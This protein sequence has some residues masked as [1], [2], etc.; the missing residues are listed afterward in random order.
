MVHG[1]FNQGNA[2]FGETA[3]IQCNCMALFAISYSAIKEINRWSQPDLDIV[4]VNGMLCTK[5]L[6]DKHY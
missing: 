3:R 6:E 2:L 5:P 1:S 4:L